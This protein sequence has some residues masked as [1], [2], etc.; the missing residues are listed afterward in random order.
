MEDSS[1]NNLVVRYHRWDNS[2]GRKGE[3]RIHWNQKGRRA[4][5]AFQF[6]IHI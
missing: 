3:F 5:R 1:I 4:R 2:T 6:W